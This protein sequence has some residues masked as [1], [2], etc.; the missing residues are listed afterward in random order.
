MREAKVLK[1]K[2]SWTDV[3][4]KRLQH[5]SSLS[6]YIPDRSKVRIILPLPPSVS[7]LSD[8]HCPSLSLSLQDISWFKADVWKWGRNVL[9]LQG[10]E[11]IQAKNWN[12]EPGRVYGGRWL[13]G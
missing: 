4:L 7:L 1:H 3:G 11:K 13:S 8:T 5:Q 9:M 6:G 2:L 10:T 12:G